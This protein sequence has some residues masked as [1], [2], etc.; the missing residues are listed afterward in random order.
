MRIYLAS[1]MSG[2]KPREEYFDKYKPKY[3]LETFFSGEKACKQVLKDAGVENF[4][5][6]SGAFSF[7]N[8]QKITEEQFDEYVDK[9]IKFI[10]END[11]KYFFEMDVD[12]IFGIDKVHQIRNKIEKETGK[13]VIPVWHKE[14]GLDYWRKMCED[15]DFVAIGGLV[16]HFKKAEYEMVKKMLNYARNRNVKVHGLGFTKTK[17]LEDFNFYSVDSTSW[18]KSAV[19]G[20]NIQ[21]FDGSIVKQRR[22]NKPKGKKLDLYALVGNNFIE[23]I[24]YQKYM[25]N[26]R[27]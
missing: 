11:I 8:G 5:L 12:I 9:Y 27:W 23:W 7:M 25:D 16:F 17:I 18:V 4:L 21:W 22:V 19:L 3:L 13:K 2:L 15:Y 10:N 24:K 20:Q 14:R 6:D 26:K 1:T